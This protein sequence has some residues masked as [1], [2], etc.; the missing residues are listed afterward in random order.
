MV[1]SKKAFSWVMVPGYDLFLIPDLPIEDK[2][3]YA[4]RAVWYWGLHRRKGLK[5]KEETLNPPAHHQCYQ[6]PYFSKSSLLRWSGNVQKHRTH[7]FKCFLPLV[8]FGSSAM[9][10]AGEWD[11]RGCN[12]EMSRSQKNIPSDNCACQHLWI[13]LIEGPLTEITACHC[14][15]SMGWVCSPFSVSELAVWLQVGV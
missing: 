14:G 5:M 1:R 15:R 6:S 2:W 7:P 9:Q 8:L 4:F 12:S 3:N 13:L 10:P 11:A